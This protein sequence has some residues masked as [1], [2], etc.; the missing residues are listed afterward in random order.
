[1][2]NS[3]LLNVLCLLYSKALCFKDIANVMHY[4]VRTLPFVSVKSG[5][6]IC[7]FQYINLLEGYNYRY[8]EHV[9]VD[10]CITQ[11]FVAPPFI[12]NLC[13]TSITACVFLLIITL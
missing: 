10:Y 11:I 7:Y 8:A 6:C 4:L 13:L 12:T 1:M 3:F 9:L 5:A 2:L